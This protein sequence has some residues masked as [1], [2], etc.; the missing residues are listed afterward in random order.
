MNAKMISL[1]TEVADKKPT[2]LFLMEDFNFP[3][4]NWDT[5]T[6]EGPVHEQD[7]LEGFR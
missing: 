6:T 4:I 1:L 3:G 5:Q 7:F 2:H